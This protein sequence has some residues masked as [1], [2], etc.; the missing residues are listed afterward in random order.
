[1]PPLLRIFRAAAASCAAN[2][3]KRSAGGEQAFAFHLGFGEGLL[4]R[5]ERLDEF[6]LLALRPLAVD[7]RPAVGLALGNLFVL[8]VTGAALRSSSV[9]TLMERF[10]LT[11][12]CR[13]ARTPPRGRG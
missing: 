3:R 11:C 4:H 12:S 1:M 5:T 10:A 7:Q 6:E 2:R 9:V 13:A 8:A